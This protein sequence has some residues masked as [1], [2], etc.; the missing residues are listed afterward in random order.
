GDVETP[1]DA[2]ALWDATGCDGVMVGRA[3]VKNPW[4]F[5]QIA[6]LRA[7]RTPLEPTLA[8]RR[9]LILYHFSL[10]R[11]REDERFALHKIRTFTGWY[12]HGLPNGR[13]LRH[14]INTLGSVSEFIDAIEGFFRELL[15]A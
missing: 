7:G 5:R 15:A 1:Q 11:D 9:G 6:A 4:I 12:T 13:E 14:R 2:L 10:L 3:A 8:E